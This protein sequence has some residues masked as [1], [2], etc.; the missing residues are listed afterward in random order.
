[1]EAC[2]ATIRVPGNDATAC[3][4]E[5][6]GNGDPGMGISEPSGLTLK[7]VIN[8]LDGSPTKT[9]CGARGTSL[10]AVGV[11]VGVGDGVGVGVVPGVGVG[12][13]IGVPVKVLRGEITHPAMMTASRPTVRI[14]AGKRW[15]L[16]LKNR[17]HEVMRGGKK[18]LAD[19]F[20]LFLNLM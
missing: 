18:L 17:T 9:N 7:P 19:R 12:P 6:I 20:A 5:L 3:A 13:L 1:M 8:G 15:G 11:G 4:A 10:E 16:Y 2:V 14:P